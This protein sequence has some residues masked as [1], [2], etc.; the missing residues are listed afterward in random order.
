ML[1]AATLWIS[2]AV[3]RPTED[4]A[5]FGR[6]FES[7]VSSETTLKMDRGEIS[8]SKSSA[9]SRK[10]LAKDINATEDLV[11]QYQGSLS[12]DSPEPLAQVRTTLDKYLSAL[13]ELKALAANGKPAA[14]AAVKALCCSHDDAYIAVL[15]AATKV[16]GFSLSALS[17]PTRYNLS[18][19]LYGAGDG[20]IFADPAFPNA[21][22][23]IARNPSRK[24]K[25]RH[26]DVIVAIRGEEE[27]EWEDVRTWKDVL[28]ASGEFEHAQQKVVV[29]VRR[30]GSL[31]QVSLISS[32][33]AVNAE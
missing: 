9:A 17:A 33:V 23:V 29:R 20:L 21:A 22:Q 25:L 1:I 7:F 32:S 4:P 15:R 13:G 11:R 28:E 2:M 3:A 18:P 30:K 16:P 27:D 12:T 19:V 8:L 26:G 24:S 6:F 5:V 10:A 14:P 31:Q